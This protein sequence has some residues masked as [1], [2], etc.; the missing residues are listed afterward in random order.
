MDALLQKYRELIKVGDNG[1]NENL[2]LRWLWFFL[3]E[4]PRRNTLTKLFSFRRIWLKSKCRLL[5]TEN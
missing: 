1:K 5:L 4:T 3:A 2:D